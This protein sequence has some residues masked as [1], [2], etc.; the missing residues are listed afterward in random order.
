MTVFK[1]IQ[2]DSSVAKN[3]EIGLRWQLQTAGSHQRATRQ[4][5]SRLAVSRTR[6]TTRASL[7]NAV[8]TEM[9]DGP[10]Q[11]TRHEGTFS[12]FAASVHP[13]VSFP[14]CLT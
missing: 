5:Q 8:T 10:Y 14:A 7:H 4:P 2:K 12:S 1:A 13:A 11:A 6:H 9:Q 3:D